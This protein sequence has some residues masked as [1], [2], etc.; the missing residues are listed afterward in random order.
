MGRWCRLALGKV[1][2][3]AALLE[4]ITDARRM[5]GIAQETGA[6]IGGKLYP[7]ALTDDLGDATSYIDLIRHNMKQLTVASAS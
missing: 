4:N 6:R 1:S 2:E 7:D 5:R 3:T